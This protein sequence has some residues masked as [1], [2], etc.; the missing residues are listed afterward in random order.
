MPAVR[1]EKALLALSFYLLLDPSIMLE[2]AA[3]RASAVL[4]AALQTGGPSEK[5]E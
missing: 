4:A 2:N 5:L 1:G 3:Q